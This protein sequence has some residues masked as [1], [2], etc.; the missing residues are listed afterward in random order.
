MSATVAHIYSFIHSK[1]ITFQTHTQTHSHMLVWQIDT[2]SMG[3]LKISAGFEVQLTRTDVKQHF[4][5]YRTIFLFFFWSHSISFCYYSISAYFIFCSFSF[6][7]S[8]LLLLPEI[9]L[10]LFY[11]TH[12]QT[13]IT[14]CFVCGSLSPFY[15]VKSVKEKCQYS[16]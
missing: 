4:I 13:Y 11:Y 8:L 5:F 2:T 16:H 1:Q 3:R 10:K 15:C 14:N 7:Y 12:T 6:Y 9:C